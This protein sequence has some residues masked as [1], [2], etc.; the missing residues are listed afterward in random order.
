MA[1]DTIVFDFGGVLVDW[2]P[3]H[4]FRKVFSD[5][6]EMEL[7][8]EEICTDDWNLEQDRGRLLSEA[9][10]LLVE[11]YPEKA[12]LIRMYYS[13][14]PEMLNGTIDGTVEILKAVKDHYK[15]YGLTNWSAETFP[16]ALERYDFFKLLDG[17][18]VSGTEKLIKPG[19]EIFNLLIERF[20]INPQKTVFVDDNIKNIEAAKTLQF[21]TIHFHN[22]E[23]LRS[24]LLELGVEL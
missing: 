22:P 10:E 16:I 4:L 12:A 19:L 23:Q 17:I 8:L 7:F 3:R 24:K 18:V 2:N 13:R 6:K 9:T 14:W 11:Q 5:E 1:I 15:V 21:K 20:N